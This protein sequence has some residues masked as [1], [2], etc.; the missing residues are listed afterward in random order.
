[1]SPIA[2]AAATNRSR[3]RENVADRSWSCGCRGKLLSK[4]A[5]EPHLYSV[6]AKPWNDLDANQKIDRAELHSDIIES[7]SAKQDPPPQAP[8]PDDQVES[9][10]EDVITQEIYES[11]LRPLLVHQQLAA[12][13][14]PLDGT[15]YRINR[16]R[17]SV[18]NSKDVVADRVLNPAAK[19][20]SG[21][22]L[23]E[24]ESIL[25]KN[26]LALNKGDI[27]IKKAENEFAREQI[28]KGLKPNGEIPDGSAPAF[29][30]TLADISG[31]FGQGR[32]AFSFGTIPARDSLLWEQSRLIGDLELDLITWFQAHGK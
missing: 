27:R 22:D 12:I 21:D 23:G 30:Q 32:F 25:K 17:V 4:Q 28:Q 1:V 7:K 11:T 3:P 31:T 10:T 14:K 8:K 29:M 6:A 9:H 5:G 15:L 24:L 2:S 18:A 16:L 13:N 20:L 19:S 26:S